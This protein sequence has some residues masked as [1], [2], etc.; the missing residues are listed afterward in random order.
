[1]LFYKLWLRH[2]IVLEG[3]C[4]T[5]EEMHKEIGEA[6][7]DSDEYYLQYEYGLATFSMEVKF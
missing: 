2:Y 1:M 5:L 7:L 6:N 3:R 4:E